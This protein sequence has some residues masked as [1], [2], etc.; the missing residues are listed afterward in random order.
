MKMSDEFISKFLQ[1]FKSRGWV[2]AW[3]KTT[4]PTFFLLM[5]PLQA[6]TL[7]STCW[8]SLVEG[9]GGW[10]CFS[11]TRGIVAFPVAVVK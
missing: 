9:V 8:K 11:Q 5:T 10:H 7:F 2:T 4:L 1:V 6:P 3:W